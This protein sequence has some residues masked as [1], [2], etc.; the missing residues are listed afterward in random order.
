MS[1]RSPSGTSSP[2]TG[3][4]A[5]RTGVLSPVSAAS[6]ISSVAATSSRPS[7]GTLSPASK[8]TM[9]PGT[10]S[11]AGMST[12]SPSRRTCAWISEH[13]LQRGDALGRLALLVQAEHRVEH[14]QADDDDAGRELLQRDDADDRGA[15]QDELHQVAVLAQKRL[16]AGLLLRLR[17]LVRARPAHAA[18]RPRRRRARAPGR[19]RAARTPPPPS[20]RATPSRWGQPPCS[21]FHPSRRSEHHL[22]SSPPHD[23]RRGFWSRVCTIRC[24]AS[25]RG[26][27]TCQTG[28]YPRS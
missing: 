21:S 22:A 7:A 12:S 19:R 24:A 6:S 10:S 16:P 17:E 13:L 26:P 25:P 4:T 8:V 20:G 27:Q 14:G 1:R 9:S 11:S 18:A 3:S 5:F 28:M 2:V 15:E 23:D